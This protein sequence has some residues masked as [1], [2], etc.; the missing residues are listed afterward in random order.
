MIFVGLFDKSAEFLQSLVKD[1]Y[2]SDEYLS[3][4]ESKPNWVYDPSEDESDNNVTADIPKKEDQLYGRC[5]L[6]I[7]FQNKYEYEKWL[8]YHPDRKWEFLVTYPAVM[9]AVY[10]FHTTLDVEIM[11]KKIIQLLQM[12]FNVHSASWQLKEYKSQLEDA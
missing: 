10:D 3:T 5:V 4:Y 1:G 9:R 6:T 11:A 8:K 2:F 12:G 7:Q